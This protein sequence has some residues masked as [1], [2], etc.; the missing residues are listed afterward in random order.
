MLASWPASGKPLN[1][2]P[3]KQTP[4]NQCSVLILTGRVSNTVGLL[5]QSYVLLKRRHVHHFSARIDIG[6]ILFRIV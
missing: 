6:F 1:N 3:L 4:K 2:R 5:E